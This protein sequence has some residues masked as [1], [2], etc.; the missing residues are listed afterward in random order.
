MWWQNRRTKYSGK[1][2]GSMERGA[3]T[4]YSIFCTTVLLEHK[5]AHKTPML[6]ESQSM[7]IAM[8]QGLPKIP[9]TFSLKGKFIYYYNTRWQKVKVS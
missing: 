1:A 3:F 7:Y 9:L 8:D 5:K 4:L 6:E 2:S